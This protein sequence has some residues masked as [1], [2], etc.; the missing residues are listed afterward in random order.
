MYKKGETVN[1]LKLRLKWLFHDLHR[2]FFFGYPWCC[3]LQFSVG[4]LLGRHS[5]AR[6]RGTIKIHDD[7]TWVPCSLHQGRHPL[8]RPYPLAKR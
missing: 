4:Q 7:H 5:Q 8:W 1:L 2:G 3:V 6:R